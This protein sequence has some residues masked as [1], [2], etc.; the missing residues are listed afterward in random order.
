MGSKYGAKNALE[1]NT[2]NGGRATGIR[3]KDWKSSLSDDSTLQFTA[4]LF[5]C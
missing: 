2:I 1:N 4:G 5:I 3:L